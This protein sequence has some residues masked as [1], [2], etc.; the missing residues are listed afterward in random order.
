M[1]VVR[2][3]P[4]L[5]WYRHELPRLE[6]WQMVFITAT[7]LPLLVALTQVGVD[8]GRMTTATQASIIGAGVLSVLVFPILA[9]ELQ[10]RKARVSSTTRPD[11]GVICAFADV[12]TRGLASEGS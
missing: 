6:R 5:F 10:R 2:G 11:L 4:A 1:L 9:I 7:A 8:N 12:H 3:L